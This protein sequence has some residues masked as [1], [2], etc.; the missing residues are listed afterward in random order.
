MLFRS[1]FKTYGQGI[2]ANGAKFFYGTQ[3][4][5][6]FGA[7]DQTGTGVILMSSSS[8]I[9]GPWKPI[10]TNI[11]SLYL[12]QLPDKSFI[13]QEWRP[14]ARYQG[15]W[16]APNITSLTNPSLTFTKQSDL[17]LTMFTPTNDNTQIL[18]VNLDDN[19]VYTATVPNY[20]S[21]SA[22]NKTGITQVIQLQNGKFAYVTTSGGVLV[23]DTLSGPTTIVNIL[24]APLSSPVGTPAPVSSVVSLTDN[25]NTTV[26]F[27]Y[28]DTDGGIII[29]VTGGEKVYKAPQID[30]LYSYAWS[31]YWGGA[32]NGVSKVSSS[33]NMFYY[34]VR[35]YRQD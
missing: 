20:G 35:D 28:E 8:D 13:A 29:G 9:R 16:T 2:L 34:G 33:R 4:K 3:S 17:R 1:F 18:A 27:I 31:N 32:F 7:G 22:T 10:T 12:R 30:G 23:S 6:R 15:V 5:E 19:K 24:S 25:A 26:K 14:G 11:L 21:W